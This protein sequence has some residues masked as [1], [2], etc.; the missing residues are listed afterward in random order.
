MVLADAYLVG[1]GI[2]VVVAAVAA[3]VFAAWSRRSSQR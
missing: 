3:L 2:G 1:E